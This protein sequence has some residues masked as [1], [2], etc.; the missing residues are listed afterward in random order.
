MLCEWR[1]EVYQRRTRFLYQTS[2][3]AINKNT[4]L[5]IPHLSETSLKQSTDPVWRRQCI[6][7]PDRAATLSRD[8]DV[9]SVSS[10][11]V[12]VSGSDVDRRTGYVAC[13]SWL[14]SWRLATWNSAICS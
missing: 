2:S 3:K 8:S 12:D 14:S 11:G 1:F 4:S 10:L 9:R 7:R 13:R 6:T 5:K